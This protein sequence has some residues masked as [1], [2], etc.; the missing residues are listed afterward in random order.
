MVLRV[1]IAL[2]DRDAAQTLQELCRRL[3]CETLDAQDLADAREK[4][5]TGGIDACLLSVRSVHRDPEILSTFAALTESPSLVLT[6]QEDELPAALALLRAGVAGVLPAPATLGTLACALEQARNERARR[7]E[8]TLQE[9]FETAPRYALIGHS[10]DHRRLLEGVARVASTPS[11]TVLLLGE[12]GSG[13]ERVARAIHAE[14]KRRPGPFVALR[15]T[16][17]RGERLAE[18]LFGRD[19]GTAR[20][21]VAG[22]CYAATGGTLYLDEVTRLDADTQSELARVLNERTWR[23]VHS[24][25]DHPLDTRIIAASQHDLGELVDRGKFDED[26]F[27]RLNVLAIPVPALRERPEDI[28][29]NA[30]ASLDRFASTLDRNPAIF[31]TEALR[32]LQSRAYPGNLPELEATVLTALLHSETNEI[33][34][35]ALQSAQGTSETAEFTIDQGDLSVKSMEKALIRHV[36]QVTD[37]NRSEAARVLQVNRATLYNKLRQYEL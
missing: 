22:L 23:R 11:T 14:S 16:A 30:Q 34:L 15:T 7:I 17:L 26:L 25:T 10:R 29:P 21:G 13:R 8:R 3:D 6:A 27:Y 19:P 33:G 35:P 18:T 28:A 2:D 1:L 9:S 20:T 5:Q 12:P 4:A 32:E 37:G 36:L 31:S 24:A